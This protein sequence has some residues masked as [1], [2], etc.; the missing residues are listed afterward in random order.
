MLWLWALWRHGSRCYEVCNCFQRAYSS[1][2]TQ[3]L[4]TFKI[5]AWKQTFLV[6]KVWLW[7]CCF[8]AVCS[9]QTLEASGREETLETNGRDRGHYEGSGR[10]EGR[11][12]W[13]TAGGHPRSL[14]VCGG[15]GVVASRKSWPDGWRKVL[16]SGSVSCKRGEY[17]YVDECT[18]YGILEHCGV[19][20]FW[21][22]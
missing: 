18:I 4:I 3:K 10:A 2:S 6:N 11:D 15:C 14:G 20:C 21:L 19:N 8:T 9:L 12:S 16:W 1:S 17:N 5:P 7:T 13:M 22:L